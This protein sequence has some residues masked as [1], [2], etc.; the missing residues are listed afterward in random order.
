MGFMA[1]DETRLYRTNE[2]YDELKIPYRYLRRL[3]T[4]LTKSNVIIS[5]QGKNGGYKISTPI[6]KISLMDI[7]VAVGDNPLSEDCFFG[8]HECAL[9]VHCVMHEKWT[10]VRENINKVLSGTKLSDLNSGRPH[11][12]GP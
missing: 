9:T 7:V 12:P 4:R 3:M 10:G 5:V 6:S 2:I 8:F 1:L 11:K